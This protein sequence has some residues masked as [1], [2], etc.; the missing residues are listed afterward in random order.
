MIVNRPEHREYGKEEPISLKW[1]DGLQKPVK[2]AYGPK[3]IYADRLRLVLKERTH[4]L[5]T[6]LSSFIMAIGMMMGLNAIR[7]YDLDMSLLFEDSSSARR[8]LGKHQYLRISFALGFLHLCDQK[9]CSSH[10]NKK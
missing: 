5:P 2:W 9:F 4:R 10:Y 7:A 6:G 8:F 1:K 3:V